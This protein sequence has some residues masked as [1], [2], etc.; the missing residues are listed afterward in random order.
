MKAGDRKERERAIERLTKLKSAIFAAEEM[1]DQSLGR[2]GVSPG[3][4][5]GMEGG[6]EKVEVGGEG[7]REG[8]GEGEE[9]GQSHGVRV[10]DE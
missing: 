7:Q 1:S 8:Q 9:V 2:S 3:A 10:G 6:E 5:R 4:R